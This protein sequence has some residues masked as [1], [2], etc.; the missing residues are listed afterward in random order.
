MLWTAFFVAARCLTNHLRPN[1]YVF[2]LPPNLN[3]SPAFPGYVLHSFTQANGVFDFAHNDC[4][5]QHKLFRNSIQVFFVHLPTIFYENCCK[6]IYQ[7][8]PGINGNAP[9][10]YYILIVAQRPQRAAG[11]IY[12]AT[13]VGR[14]LGPRAIIV[15]GFLGPHVTRLPACA[16]WP[17]RTEVVAVR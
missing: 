1:L 7:F 15:G 13:F 9:N 10:K 4:S 8:S 17:L 6:N 11:L 12:R 2:N 5:A 14:P 3:I 16:T